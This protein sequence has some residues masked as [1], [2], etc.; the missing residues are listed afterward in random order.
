MTVSRGYLSNR[1]RIYPEGIVP[2]ANKMEYIIYLVS[3][4]GWRVLYFHSLIGQLIKITRD[5][6][7]SK[8]RR[9]LI[10]ENKNFQCF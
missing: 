4:T 10:N 5:S 1:F 9:G 7:E 3:G 2:L 8:N 6:K